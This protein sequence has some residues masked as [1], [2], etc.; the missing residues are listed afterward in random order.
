[1]RQAE[2]EAGVR[3]QPLLSDAT[4]DRVVCAAALRQ[5]LVVPGVSCCV[6]RS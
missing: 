4:P 6:E 1:V 2:R 5:L 3:V